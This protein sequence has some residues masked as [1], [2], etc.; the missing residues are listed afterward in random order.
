MAVSGLGTILSAGR[1]RAFFKGSFSVEGHEDF[2]DKLFAES[3]IIDGNVN[4]GMQRGRSSSPLEPGQIKKL[5]GINIGGH[6][7]LVSTLESR[8]LWLEKRKHA[9]IRI[10]RA[11]DLEKAVVT[12]R[13]GIL[14]YV[15]SDFDLKGSLETLYK[16]KEGG[17]RVFQLTFS[18]NEIG[19]GANSDDMPLTP[20]G[21]KVVRELNRLRMVVDISHCGMRTTLGAAEVSAHPITANHANVENLAKSSRNKSNEELKAIAATG[22]VIGI[23]TIN[24]FLVKDP[25]RPA[26]IDDLIAH[27]DYIVEKIG[28][29]HV[30]VGSDSYMDGTQRYE[31]DFSDR[32]INSPERWKHVARRLYQQGYSREDLQKIF[33]LNF[34]RVY[35]TVL[36]P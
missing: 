32:Y 17:I 11:S 27:I 4:L 30:G 28:I 7:T 31:V 2:V 25:T 22:G 10:E 34:K 33:G 19:G 16:Y 20:F 1:G 26:T 23:T 15:Q 9:L 21:K 24:R 6:T 29:N 13:Y 36:E 14:Y 12:N 18:D 3:I 8:N 35:D 5:T